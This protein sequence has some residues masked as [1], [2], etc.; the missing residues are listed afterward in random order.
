LNHGVVE[1]DRTLM[2]TQKSVLHFDGRATFNTQAIRSK[3]TADTKQFDSL[4]LHAPVLIDGKLRSPEISIGRKIP[5]PT[6]DFGG[7][8]DVDCRALVGE[9]MAAK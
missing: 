7:A 5:I 3:I 1:F 6:P 8:K 4:D 9:L 2:D